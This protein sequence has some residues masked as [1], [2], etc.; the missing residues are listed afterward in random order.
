M[1]CRARTTVDAPEPRQADSG[2]P[3]RRIGA[4][5]AR[6]RGAVCHRRWRHDCIRRPP[7]GL[8]R[9]R[10]VVSHGR[11]RQPDGVAGRCHPR[12]RGD[13]GRDRQD[14]APLGDSPHT[15]RRR[16]G[17]G[18]SRRRGRAARQADAAAHRSNGRCP[19]RCCG[20]RIG[21]APRR[22]VGRRSHGAPRRRQAVAAPACGDSGR[23]HD[24]G[25]PDVARSAD[26]PAWRRRDDRAAHDHRRGG[27]RRH[28]LLRTATGQ[29][30]CDPDPDGSD[31]RRRAGAHA[32]SRIDSGRTDRCADAEQQR[33][34]VAGTFGPAMLCSEQ[35]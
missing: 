11:L 20:G 17:S 34:H 22:T 26:R 25:F 8:D 6:R 7:P 29:T 32:R 1:G 9:A 5:G 16:R 15:R 21:W 18:G 3:S 31:S 19:S 35:C 24:L 28:R 13:T 14:A 27:P 2:D 4:G 33:A 10:R 30:R 12:G 23:G